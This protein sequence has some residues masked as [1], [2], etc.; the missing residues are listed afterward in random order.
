VF[1]VFGVPDKRRRTYKV[2]EE[3]QTPDVV[4][5]ITSPSTKAEDLGSK[6]GVYAYLGVKEY[7]LYDPLGDYLHPAFQGYAL[8]ETAPMS[9]YRP[10]AS[11]AEGVL[12]SRQLELTLRVEEGLLRLYDPA[13]GEK[14]LTPQE[15]QAARRAEAAARQAAEARVA[16]LEAELA[17]LHGLE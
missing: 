3:G 6:K 2:W 11:D 4:F 5:E 1:V 9:V 8:D 17:R 10:I 15:A 13:T 7:F 12:C 16:E 14:L